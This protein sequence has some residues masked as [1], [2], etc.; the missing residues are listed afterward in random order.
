MRTT[1][2]NCRIVDKSVLLSPCAPRTH[3]APVDTPRRQ[4]L[5]R[6]A[7][8][9]AGRIPRTTL[10]EVLDIPKATGYRIL[11]SQDPRRSERLHYRGRK[12]ILA[13]Y[14]RAAIET[15]EDSNFR[16]TASNHAVV[17]RA[18]DISYGSDRA[19]QRNMSEY[20]IGT[21]RAVQ[22]RFISKA[23]ITKR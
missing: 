19:I 17:V 18:I 10:F 9:Y 14:Q 15:V 7:K 16:F 2:R 4:R 6:D 1:R 3:N 22:K 5:L 20:E 12:S 23:A 11:K 21:Y 8:A 13:P